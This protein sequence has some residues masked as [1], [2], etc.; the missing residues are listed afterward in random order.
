MSILVDNKPIEV[1]LR[2]VDRPYAGG[3]VGAKVFRSK[4]EEE[5]WVSKENQRRSEKAME[6]KALKKDVTPRLEKNAQ[7]EVKELVTFWRR[8]DW[9][10]QTEIINECT[11]V[12]SDGAAKTD[13]SKYRVIQMQK[14][15][16]GW[17]LKTADGEPIKITPE[18]VSKL[19]FAVALALLDR[20]ET[21]I[22]PDEMEMENLE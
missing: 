21:A 13:Y 17:N 14:L 4:D 11:I 12:N 5:E 16:M 15:M 2:Y 7:E 3:A 1:K 19:D 10:T 9:G 8:T 6:L 18:I 20:Y 22:S